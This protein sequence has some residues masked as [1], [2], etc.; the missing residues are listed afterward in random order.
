MHRAGELTQVGVGMSQYQQGLLIV[1]AQPCFLL[2]PEV[3]ERHADFTFVLLPG[4][5]SPP[6]TGL[7]PQV[8]NVFILVRVPFSIFYYSCL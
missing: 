2:L 4:Q 6:T 1:L 5:P 3:N 7:F 8:T